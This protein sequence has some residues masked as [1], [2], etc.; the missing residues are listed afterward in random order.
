MTGLLVLAGV[1]V[2]L[3]VVLASLLRWR[4]HDDRRLAGEITGARRYRRPY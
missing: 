4:R 3:V 1:V 2:A